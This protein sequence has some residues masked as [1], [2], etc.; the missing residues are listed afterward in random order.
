MFLFM[1][2]RCKARKG[3]ISHETYSKEHQERASQPTQD[4]SSDRASGNKLD[5]RR[6][7]DEPER[8]LAT[9]NCRRA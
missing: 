7:D 3:V 5:V 2:G 9:G 1:N 4:D 8:K 6:G